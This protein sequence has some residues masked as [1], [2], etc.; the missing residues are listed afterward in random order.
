M[1]YIGN[2]PA[3]N[4][5]GRFYYTATAAQTVFSG[6]DSNGKTLAYQDGGYVDVYLNGVL[7]QDTIDYTAT[8]K[9]SITLVSG[10]TAGDLIEIVAYGIFSVADT[11][12]A[13]SGGTFEGAVT[14]NSD[15]TVDTDTLYVDSTNNRVG[16]GTTSPDTLVEVSADSGNASIKFARS[17]TASTDDDFG[18]IVFENSVGTTLASIRGVSKSGN[19]E[20]GIT[21]GAGGGDATRMTLDNSGNLGIGTGSPTG[22]GKILHLNGSSTVADFHMTNSTSGSTSTDGFILRYSGLNAEFLNREAGSNIFYTSG[23]ERMRINQAGQVTMGSSSHADDILYLTRSNDGK[24]QRF[25]KG[26]TEVGR[27]GV[28][29]GGM[30]IGDSDVGIEMDGAQNAIRPCNTNTPAVS[31]NY[32]SLGTSSSRWKDIYAVD[33][34]INSS[35]QTE[36]QQIVSLTDDE[37]VA[38]KAISKLFKTYKW[39]SS[40]EVKG[41]AARTHTGVIAQEVEQAMTDAGL[42]AGNYAFFIKGVWWETQT[43]VPAVDEVVDEDGNVI[44]EAKEA[45]TRTDT[46]NTLEEAPDDATERTRLGIRYPELLAFIGAA[47]EQRLTSIEARL[48]ALENA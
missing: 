22:S 47:T 15:L 27:I 4:V 18:S 8:T 35:D 24:L 45:Y 34:S 40:V 6:A 26:A 5:R 28:V 17:N 46:Y 14:I 43:E 30:F 11:V 1:P 39:N 23:T 9:T 16:I 48:D 25:F 32:L 41:D 7:L 21:F 13:A 12:S 10:A 42:D 31:D 44:T 33:T 37:I 2:S 38:A 3:N 20:A 36:K 19:T 29:G